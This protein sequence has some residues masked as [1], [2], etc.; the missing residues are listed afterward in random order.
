LP[1]KWPPST[2]DQSRAPIDIP[3]LKTVPKVIP[4]EIGW[5]LFVDDFLIEKT[6]LKRRYYLAEKFNGNPILMPE[7]QT[8]LNDGNVPVAAPFKD[9]IWYDEKDHLF[10]MWY[11]AGWFC[12]TA[13]AVSKDGI[14]WQ[15][16]VLDVVP[17]TN[18][19]LKIRDGYKR[20]GCTVRPI[21]T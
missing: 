21:W 9:G 1:K 8:E 6:T 14:N 2:I 4:I 12:G 20:D 17:G 16:P 19:V 18:L 11:H 13:Y 10:K 7:T 3:Y 15:R 5:Q